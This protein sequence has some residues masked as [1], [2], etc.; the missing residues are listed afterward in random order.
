M[1]SAPFALFL[2]MQLESDWLAALSKLDGR[3]LI[4]YCSLICRSW[5]RH[6]SRLQSNPPRFQAP[7]FQTP[8]F[9]KFQTTMRRGSAGKWAIWAG[10]C[11]CELC[12]VNCVP[13][14]GGHFHPDLELSRR[15]LRYCAV[16][17]NLLLLLDGFESRCLWVPFK[18]P[19]VRTKQG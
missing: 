14:A 16:S 10:V 17:E 5:T 1:P 8:R 6:H 19:L 9:Q 18:A 4:A 7:E 12:F 11:F 13:F 3:T 15:N 2:I